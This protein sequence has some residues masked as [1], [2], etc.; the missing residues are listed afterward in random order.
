MLLCCV[1]HIR[2][3]SAMPKE[4]MLS[5]LDKTPTDPEE[6]A[7]D[8]LRTSGKAWGGSRK[9]EISGLTWGSQVGSLWF[10]IGD[11]ETGGSDAG[12]PRCL[13]EAGRVLGICIPLRPGKIIYV[14]DRGSEH[15]TCRS[16]AAMSSASVFYTKDLRESLLEVAPIGRH[17]HHPQAYCRLSRFHKAFKSLSWRKTQWVG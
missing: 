7:K 8:L 12:L 5:A 17:L 13:A 16:Y 11:S 14:H 1:V 6:L 15:T 4:K 10:H 2:T 9:R 3:D